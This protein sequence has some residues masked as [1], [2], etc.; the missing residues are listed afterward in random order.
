[1]LHFA[2]LL[3]SKLQSHFESFWIVIRL[4]K[5]KTIFNCITIVS[6][7]HQVVTCDQSI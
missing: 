3:D 6:T 4:S 1:M 7:K 5:V 2:H